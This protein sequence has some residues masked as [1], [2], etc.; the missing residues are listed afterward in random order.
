MIP[1]GGMDGE[2]ESPGQT[3]RR[4]RRDPGANQTQQEDDREGN[5]P[6]G[7]GRDSES[8]EGGNGT[9]AQ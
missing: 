3:S 9:L 4:L 2:V 8:L 6:A 1:A 7:H 5:E